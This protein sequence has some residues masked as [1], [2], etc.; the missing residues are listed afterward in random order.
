MIIPI[1]PRLAFSG[2]GA[3]GA[4]LLVACQSVP[5]Q[6]KPDP[7][8]PLDLFIA[9]D[10]GNQINLV[11]G[12]YSTDCPGGRTYTEVNF[13]QDH[14][15]GSP[16]QGQHFPGPVTRFRRVQDNGTIR[17]EEENSFRFIKF[18]RRKI[19]HGSTQKPCAQQ[20]WRG[21]DGRILRSVR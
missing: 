11:A 3:L 8:E 4:L 2:L 19:H 16:T 1:N 13:F 6:R 20:R 15:S 17:C 21:N 12:G 10:K 5:R 7:D 18:L 9:I 14:R